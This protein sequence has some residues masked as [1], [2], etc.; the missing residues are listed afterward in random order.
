MHETHKKIQGALKCS[1]GWGSESALLASAKVQGVQGCERCKDANA[2]AK[3]KI[4][5]RTEL[6]GIKLSLSNIEQLT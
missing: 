6:P 3:V 5:P 4:T 2:G 1:K